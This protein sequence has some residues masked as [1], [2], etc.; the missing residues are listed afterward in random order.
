MATYHAS[1][2]D[3]AAA[4]LE[5]A[6][7]YV[8]WIDIGL[9]ANARFVPLLFGALGQ[10]HGGLRAAAADV[11]T[12]IVGK[13]MEA[14]AKLTLVQQLGVAP[15]CAA[16]AGGL[17]GAGEEPEMAARYARLLAAL[18][19]E[20]L[21][22]WKKV[23]NSVLSMAAVG[24]PVDDEASRE[25]AAACA[26]AS[27]LLDALMPAVLSALRTGGE[28]SAPAVVPFLLSYVNRL[29]AAVKRAAGGGGGGGG[30]GAPGGK[31]AEDGAA[32]SPGGGA[33]AVPGVQHLPAIIEALAAAAR[34]P[35]DSSAYAADP[36]SSSER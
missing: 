7:R 26:T 18:A 17:P 33:A 34:F 11:L 22:S 28:E 4:V 14:I 24:L 6:A 16:W 15:V 13:R 30:G 8:H 29:K 35:E 36:A 27:A 1:S 21:E 25:A 12:E 20:V 31:G 2:P 9:V 32:G 3:T 19:G 23:E 5:T 10:G